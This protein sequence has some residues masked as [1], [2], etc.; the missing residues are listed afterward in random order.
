MAMLPG[1]RS[2]VVRWAIR[3][4][5]GR[6]RNDPVKKAIAIT[7]FEMSFHDER[8]PDHRLSG[9]LSRR[10]FLAL[11]AA[12]AAGATLFDAPRV[13]RAAALAADNDPYAG[14]P[15]GAQSYSLRKFGVVE[16][17]RHIQGMGLHYV[18]FFG[19]H[20]AVNASPETL[21]ETKRLLADADVELRAHGVNA[22]T[23]DHE[24]NRKVFDF[25][26]RAGFKNITA[27]PTYDSFD[28]LDKLVE[29]YGI[30]VCIHNHGPGELYDTIEDVKDRVKDRHK[31]IGAC[32]DT[33]HFIRSKIDPV[34]AVRELGDR[35]F[36]LH[37]KDEAKQEKESHNVVLGKGHLDVVG[38]F[39]AL[40]D[41]RFPA[42]G[43]ISL[44]YEANPDNP[45]ED[46]KQCLAV[47][48]ESLA[49]LNA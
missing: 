32:V 1:R 37:V 27:N 48:R 31:L 47:V 18:E 8:F 45:V 29:E 21:A 6:G 11:S 35:V 23:A 20:L 26:K 5:N 44:E 38:L 33:G 41:I 24:A 28:S 40:R 22:F 7:G 19:E 16:A 30:R 12:A 9:G 3:D 14:F 46:M 10:R 34:K 43:S 15:I 17:V 36:A 13:L 39:Q 2:R 25:A 42:D 4:H 49:K